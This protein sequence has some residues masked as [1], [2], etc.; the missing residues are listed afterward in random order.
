MYLS[1]LK[2]QL[3]NSEYFSLKEAQDLLDA[4][5]RVYENAREYEEILLRGGQDVH[6]PEEMSQFVKENA[7]MLIHIL[8]TIPSVGIRGIVDT[9]IASKGYDSLLSELED[10]RTHPQKVVAQDDAFLPDLGNHPF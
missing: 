2:R 8:I 9:M 3:R 4:I 7:E 10:W 1:W 6:P 5:D